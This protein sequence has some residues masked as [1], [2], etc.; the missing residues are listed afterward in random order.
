MGGVTS[1]VPGAPAGS[2]KPGSTPSIVGKAGGSAPNDGGDP[3]G[4][5][6]PGMEPAAALPKADTMRSIGKSAVIDSTRPETVDFIELRM[7]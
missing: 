5:R 4:G 6:D 7:R 3:K 1:I 2:G